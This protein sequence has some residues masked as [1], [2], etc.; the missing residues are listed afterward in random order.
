MSAKLKCKLCNR[1]TGN[2][3][4][5]KTHVGIT[6][7]F[8]NKILQERGYKI[9]P[10]GDISLKVHSCQICQYKAKYKQNL[11]IHYCNH[12]MEDLKSICKTVTSD[13]KCKICDFLSKNETDMARP[14][15]VSHGYIN[16]FLK[17]ILS[18]HPSS[19]K[20]RCYR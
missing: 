16:R 2:K 10:K 15:G 1:V 17:N 18:V 14:V 12:F 3:Q 6:H 19:E 7:G 8:I 4:Q 20:S 9:I 13:L 5:M 11:E